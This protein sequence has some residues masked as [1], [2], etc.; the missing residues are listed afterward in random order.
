MSAQTDVKAVLAALASLTTFFVGGVVA[1][2]DL[3]EGGLTRDSYPAAWDSNLILKPTLV[4]KERKQISTFAIRDARA[5][6]ASHLQA[7]EIWYYNAP[8][9]T[10]TALETAQ[11]TVYGALQDQVIGGNCYMR[12]D[13]QTMQRDRMLDNAP[14]I[15]DTYDAT[16]LTTP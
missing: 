11:R 4:I 1:Y 15:M 8:S 3:G 13:M 2:S 12:R 10:Y 6:V 14:V 16:G 5:Q 9:G 7:V